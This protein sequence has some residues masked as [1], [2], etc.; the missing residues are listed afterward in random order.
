MSRLP[1][2]WAHED[3]NR[4]EIISSVVKQLL[5]TAASMKGTED[6]GKRYSIPLYEKEETP[7]S[8]PMWPSHEDMPVPLKDYV[9]E[10]E[11]AKEIARERVKADLAQ[12]Q[13]GWDAAMLTKQPRVQ[14]PKDATHWNSMHKQWRR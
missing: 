13:A 10:E 11:R 14:C 9:T 5:A 12:Y 6:R 3:S 4:I 7:M 8:K 1:R 2:A